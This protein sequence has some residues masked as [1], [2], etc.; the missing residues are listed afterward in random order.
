LFAK[1]R[2]GFSE[3]KCVKYLLFGCSLFMN[4]FMGAN[5]QESAV[6]NGEPARLERCLA[7]DEKDIQKD[8]DTLAQGFFDAELAAVDLPRIVDRKWFELGMP[9]LLQNEVNR[10]IDSVREDTSL[11]RRFTSSFSPAQTTELAEQIA[12]RAFSSEAFRSRLETLASEVA[13]DFTRTFNSVAARSAGETAACLE[14]YLGNIY[15]GAVGNAFEEEIRAQVE[16][17]GATAL[18]EDFESEGAVGAPTVIGAATIAGSYVA[19]A[20]AQRLS[21]QIT[22]RI[23]GN[24]TAR[25]LGRAGTSA[26]PVVGW[27]VG[28]GLIVF[29]VVNSGLRGPFPA[30]RRQLAGEETQRQIQN[31]IIASLREDL[32]AVSEE[33]SAG[34]S[35]EV[36]AQWQGFTQSFEEILLLAEENAAFRQSLNNTSE[37][38]LPTLAGIVELA[39]HAEVVEAAQQNRLGRAVQLGE[40]TIKILEAQPSLKTVLAWSEVAGPRFEKVVEYE[41]YRHKAPTDFSRRSLAR[42]V[43]TDDIHTISALS[44]LNRDEMNALLGLSSSTLNALSEQ[45]RM[46]DFSTVA[47]YAA[48][49]EPEARDAFIVR[50]LEEPARLERF[51]PQNVRDAVVNS[52]E[53]LQAVVFV[54][55]EPTDGFFGLDSVLGF[56]HDL[57]VVAAGTVS[58]RLLSAKYPTGTLSLFGIIFVALSIAVI[59]LLITLAWRL[60]ALFRRTRPRGQ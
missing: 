2:Y 47:W 21:T 48:A 15:G 26:I 58:A 39:P 44:L 59:A 9:N 12:N 50:L 5:A 28:G 18:V 56:A 22:R 23:A 7:L 34:I 4:L 29:D 27:A 35:A 41:I 55:N 24:I 19:R 54:G 33:M 43:D 31:E 46:Q 3:G 8:I 16:E 6:E 51:V 36:Y 14:R 25:I 38:G 1:L 20:V 30:I 10:A 42:L 49:L 11:P 52:R 13:S 17:A 57:S 53:P 60:T 45:L 37:E 32:P 40:D